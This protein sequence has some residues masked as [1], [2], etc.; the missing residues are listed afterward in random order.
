MVV[1]N[2]SPVS[3]LALIGHL[4]LLGELYGKVL[5]PEAVSRELAR[6]TSTPS[7][8]AAVR[9]SAWIEVRPVSDRQLVRALQ[10]RLH[11]GESEAIALAL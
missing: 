3:G 11:S 1:S 5:V 7:L 8:D 6:T 10:A 9:S 4:G 2:T